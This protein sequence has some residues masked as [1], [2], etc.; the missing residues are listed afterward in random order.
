MENEHDGNIP[1]FSSHIYDDRKQLILNPEFDQYCVI[2]DTLIM[3]CYYCGDCKIGFQRKANQ[4]FKHLV[5]AHEGVSHHHLT[6]H[7]LTEYQVEK[8]K[9]K[10][11]LPNNEYKEDLASV[12]QKT[13]MKITKN[14]K[15]IDNIQKPQGGPR[16]R[17]SKKG[18]AVQ[19]NNVL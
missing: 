18:P 5:N 10:K 19:H 11:S 4:F 17:S 15:V 9:L 6:S 2:E 13:D 8:L 7:L 1:N 3:E 14:L 12:I 16:T